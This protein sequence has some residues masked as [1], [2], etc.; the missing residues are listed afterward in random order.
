MP[1]LLT[2]NVCKQE[3]KRCDWSPAVYFESKLISDPDRAMCQVVAPL[4]FSAQLHMVDLAGSQ[5]GQ[6]STAEEPKHA[7]A[8]L[9]HLEDV[10]RAL[11]ATPLT[12]LP[13]SGTDSSCLQRT[14]AV[15]E[16]PNGSE[17]WCEAA[18]HPQQCGPAE[19]ALPD[20]P[21]RNSRLTMVLQDSFGE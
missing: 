6:G 8:S 4:S 12:P 16:A 5:A 2:T 9:D 17:V 13:L 19:C 3:P 14:V 11:Q 20:V 18:M 10:V 1:Q 21:Y 7:N 15:N